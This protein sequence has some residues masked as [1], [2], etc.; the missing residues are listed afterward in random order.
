MFYLFFRYV[1]LITAQQV[2]IFMSKYILKEGYYAK[3]SISAN[4]FRTSHSYSSSSRSSV[5]FL[6][7]FSERILQAEKK[8]GLKLHTIKKNW[9]LLVIASKIQFFFYAYTI[10]LNTISS[11]AF[12]MLLQ[13]PTHAIWW[14]A[15]NALFMLCRSFIYPEFFRT[16]ELSSQHY[17]HCPNSVSYYAR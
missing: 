8:N 12:R 9:T 11:A 15:F 10:S 17:H 5:L 1:N 7:S 13:A 4:Y 14:R 3:K 6:S 16:K 2:S